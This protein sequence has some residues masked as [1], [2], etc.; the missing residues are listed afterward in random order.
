MIEKFKKKPV[1][2]EAVQYTGKNDF[3]IGKWSNGLVYPSPVLEP[4]ENNPSGSY[5]QIK[6][7]KGVMP[8]IVGDWII[9][10]VKGE[11]YPCKNDIFLMTYEVS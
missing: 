7:L 6:T 5:L 11:F 3:E 2:I 9:K 8:A 4:T 10:G 1:E